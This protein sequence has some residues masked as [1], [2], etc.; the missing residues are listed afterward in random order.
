LPPVAPDLEFV[1]LSTLVL[2][3]FP[4]R[5]LFGAIAANR[6]AAPSPRLHPRMVGK[7]QCAPVSFTGFHTGEIFFTHELCQCLANRQQ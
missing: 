2:E 5:G 4:V 1:S 3:P 6:H 7:Y